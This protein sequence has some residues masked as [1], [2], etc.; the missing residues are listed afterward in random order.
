MWPAGGHLILTYF[1]GIVDENDHIRMD[2]INGGGYPGAFLDLLGV[3]MEEFFPLRPGES[4]ELS[5]F[6]SGRLLE[7]AGTDDDGGGMP[8]C[9]GRAGGR[10][11]RGDPERP[12]DGL[13]YYVATSLGTDGMANWWRSSA[14]PRA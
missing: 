1:S 8:R 9:L 12:G 13:A 5:S 7:R 14:A 10:L 3:R 6:G 2:P 11:S 4:V